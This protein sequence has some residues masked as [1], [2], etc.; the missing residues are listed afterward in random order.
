LKIQAQGI[1]LRN[2]SQ[3]A[4]ATSIDGITVMGRLE[5]V[6]YAAE[7]NTFQ[8]VIGGN[9]LHVPGTHPVEIRR[10]AEADALVTANDIG[11]DVAD[12]LEAVE[13]AA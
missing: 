2:I 6:A 3:L 12:S 7:R 13:R 9:T 5:S 10:T 1:Q 8:L 4:M 11:H